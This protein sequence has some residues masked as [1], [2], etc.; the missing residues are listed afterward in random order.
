MKRFV[1]GE[2]RSQGTLLPEHLDDYVAQDNPVRVVDAFVEHLD[3]RKLGF[4][5]V[6]RSFNGRP[7]YPGLPQL[8]VHHQSSSSSS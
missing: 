8:R 1:E 5:R 6:D 4:E 3:L 2:E 7:A